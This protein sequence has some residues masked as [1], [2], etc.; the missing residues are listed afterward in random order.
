MVMMNDDGDNGD[1]GDD[2]D[3]EDA[4]DDDEPIR[5]QP[6]AQTKS[7]CVDVLLVFF[8]LRLLTMSRRSLKNTKW[9]Q[10]VYRSHDCRHGDSC[11]HAHTWAEYNLANAGHWPSPGEALDNG[12]QQIADADHA[13]ENTDAVAGDANRAANDGGHEIARHMLDATHMQIY[14]IVYAYEP[15]LAVRIT[16]MLLSLDSNSLRETM[17]TLRL[18]WRKVEEGRVMLV[19]NGYNERGLD[20]M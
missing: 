11:D 6:L 4:D 19:D 18:M 14:T 3:Y 5:N 1:G 15:A 9:C 7:C 2:C 8:R 10:F 17:N 20:A 16:G 13:A 12:P